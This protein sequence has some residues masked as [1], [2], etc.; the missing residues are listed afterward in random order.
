MSSPAFRRVAERPVHQGHIWRV[1]V[2]TVE[3]P[4]GEHFERDVVISPG[5][6]GV[7]PVLA[8]AEGNFSVVLVR[9]YRA[10]LDTE[11]LEIPAGMRDV[12][13]EP[14]TETA[15]RELI[16]ETGFAPGRLELL[17]T[18]HNSAGMTDALTYVFVATDLTPAEGVR[19]GPEEQA[20]EVL[21]VP[22]RDAVG[23]I[24]RGEI[25]DAKTVIGVLAAERA[26]GE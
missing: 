23:M 22:L 1:A 13:G 2:V 15:R 16:E 6:V 9:Q 3:G 7:V 11:L 24:G 17:S 12:E 4:D 25:T 10:T 20:M 19:Q 8:D 5:A 14:P 26:L 18:F 21:Q